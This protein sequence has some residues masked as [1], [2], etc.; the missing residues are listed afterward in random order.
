MPKAEAEELKK[1]TLN[2][3][4]KDYVRLGDLF[5]QSGAAK[6][7]RAIVRQYLQEFDRRTGEAKLEVDL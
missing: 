1:V 4:E 2:M 5:P 3:Y 6:A 7:I